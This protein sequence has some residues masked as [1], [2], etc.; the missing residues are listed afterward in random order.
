MNEH[1]Q[2]LSPKTASVDDYLKNERRSPAKNE[3]L[4]GKVI[5]R[6]GS[7]RWH[8]LIVSNVAIGIGSRLHGHKC[9]IYISNIRVKLANN[10]IC[11]PDI[12]IVNG[13]PTFADNGLDL[14]LDPTVLID[15]VSNDT[16]TSAK[17]TKL[18]SFLAMPSIKECL[19]IKEDEMRI[20]HYTR[21]NAK[22]WLYKIYN[23]RDDVISL[24]A[25]GCKMSLQEVYAQIKFRQAEFSSKAVN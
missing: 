15:V 16:H 21:Q 6:S 18:E 4:N 7:S 1:I 3:Y 13:E 19:L 25:I 24:D 23:E 14:L 5:G 22:Q 9:E 20:E 17:T 11:Y 2:H 12:A 10:Y 8:N